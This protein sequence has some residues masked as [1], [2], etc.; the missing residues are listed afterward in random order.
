MA[1]EEGKRAVRE[2]RETLG[3][4]A[5]READAEGAMRGAVADLQREARRLLADVGG[6]RADR[7]RQILSGLDALEREYGQEAL[8][9]MRPL[10]REGADLG[11]EL[12]DR[13]LGTRLIQFAPGAVS[14][15]VL[16]AS[17]GVT[18]SLIRD[19]GGDAARAIR[20]E[21]TLGATGVRSYA[22]VVD[23]IGANLEDPGPFVS[24]AARSDAI[25]RTEIGRLA[26]IAS[27]GRQEQAVQSVPDLEKMWAHGAVGPL[28]RPTHLAIHGQ[29]RRVSEDFD[30]PAIN[31]GRQGVLT[32]SAPFPRHPSLSAA[33]SVNCLCQSVPHRA[34]WGLGAPE[35][36]MLGAR[37]PQA[38]VVF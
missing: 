4:I 22:E 15:T 1:T 28:S 26:A 33:N 13:V 32:E 12:V 5:A 24:L 35:L 6:F 2:I 7:L 29:V 10:L 36:R 27:Q 17:E 37:R 3:R 38:G 23:A 8:R 25:A 34:A 19:I 18:A 30:L 14:R 31:A 9:R 21:V 20:R 11:E 16:E